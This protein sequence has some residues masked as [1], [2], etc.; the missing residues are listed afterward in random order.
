MR[1]LARVE[2]DRIDELEVGDG[3]LEA[4]AFGRGDRHGGML[5]GAV[6]YGHRVT[7]DLSLFGRVEAGYRYGDNRG[8]AWEALLGGRWM[9]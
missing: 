8:F 7:D 1:Y 3:L 2:L 4:F 6:E 9:L 5:G